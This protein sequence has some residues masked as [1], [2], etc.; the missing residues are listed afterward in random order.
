MTQDMP[1][2]QVKVRFCASSQSLLCASHPVFLLPFDSI[3][4]TIRS[5][6]GIIHAMAVG[7]GIH[8]VG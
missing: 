5:S 6:I 1:H 4:V 2:P 3:F 7:I 8:P